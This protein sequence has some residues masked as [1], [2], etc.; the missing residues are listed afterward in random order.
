[1]ETVHYSVKINASKER[2]WDILWGDLTYPEWTSVFTE[3]S[4]VVTDW[5][6]GSKVLFLSG[7]DDGMY[8]VIEEKIPN[9]YM[10]F[11][12]LGMVKEGKELPIDE[13][14]KK[15]SGSLEKYSLK[16]T[17]DMTILKVD[18]DTEES[19]V[20]SFNKLFPAALKKVKD[21]AEDQ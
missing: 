9:E 21:L 5:E 20:E 7:T 15:W 12:D 17:D 10:S 11:K 14:T 13:E 4:A 2:V 3:G 1:M 8:S 16:E 18:L 19:S 6:K